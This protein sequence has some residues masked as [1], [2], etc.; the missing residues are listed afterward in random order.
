[1]HNFCLKCCCQ[2]QLKINTKQGQIHTHKYT[3]KT[4]V[5]RCNSFTL[6]LLISLAAKTYHIEFSLLNKYL[7]VFVCQS[8][9]LILDLSSLSADAEE[10]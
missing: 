5:I 9:A 1:M 7:S 4:P 10:V 6:T 8:E 3:H 2:I